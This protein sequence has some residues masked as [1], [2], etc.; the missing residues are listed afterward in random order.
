MACFGGLGPQKEN[1]ESIFKKCI[2]NFKR[3]DN[4]KLRVWATSIAA[5]NF[6]ILN[7]LDVSQY[8]RDLSVE[9]TRNEAVASAEESIYKNLTIKFQNPPTTKR[10]RRD[11]TPSNSNYSVTIV[12]SENC[13]QWHINNCNISKKFFLFQANTA[14][15]L[16]SNKLPLEESVFEI[17]SIQ[18]IMLLKPKQYNSKIMEFIGE[19]NL[20]S[21]CTEERASW[22]D[23][24]PSF[25]R[26][27]I[28]EIQQVIA[29]YVMRRVSLKVS[30]HKLSSLVLDLDNYKTSVVNS[31][32]RL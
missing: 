32:R 5:N 26:E 18:N 12:P 30:V 24:C 9:E 20:N 14:Q 1:A 31:I 17:T 13:N 2:G 16:E 25:S 19:D 15:Q 7:R 22:V 10:K 3:A 27:E 6:E 11:S 21:I 4:S 23:D 28:F 8:W 29:D